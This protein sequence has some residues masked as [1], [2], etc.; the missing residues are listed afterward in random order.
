LFDGLPVGQINFH[1]SAPLDIPP[2]RFS[3]W[4][5]PQLGHLHFGGYLW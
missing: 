5:L 3:E 4:R 2:T 1:T